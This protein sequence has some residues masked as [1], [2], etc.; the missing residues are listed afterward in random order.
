MA[1]APQQAAANASAIMMRTRALRARALRSALSASRVAPFNLA[2]LDPTVFWLATLWRLLPPGPLSSFFAEAGGCGIAQGGQARRAL[3]Q[4]A[5]PY[6]AD[7]VLPEEPC[8]SKSALNEANAGQIPDLR[9]LGLLVRPPVVDPHQQPC[10]QK[11]P[12]DTPPPRL[13]Y[14]RGGTPRCDGA[15]GQEAGV[16]RRSSLL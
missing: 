12:C 8:P 11:A 10:P 7:K 3:I 1:S 5:A 13:A 4:A 15:G 6:E 2:M 16:T 9:T 14:D